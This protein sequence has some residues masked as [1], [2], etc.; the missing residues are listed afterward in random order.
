MTQEAVRRG[1]PR[2]SNADDA[3]HDATLRL[4]R[5]GGPRAVTVEAVSAESGAARTTIYRRHRDREELLRAVLVDLVEA[6]LPD[7]ELPLEGKLHWLLDRLV[8]LLEGIGSGGSA[9]LLTNSDHEFAKTVRGLLADRLTVLSAAMAADADAGR[10]AP[11]VDPD[12]LVGLLLGAHL[13]EQL[14]YG[15]PRPGWR[16]RTVDLLLPAVRP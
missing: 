6:P 9:A 1:R 13:S 10:L 5:R 3:I 11:H 7:P 4:L 14:R 16:V 12:T 8:A 2:S 15:E